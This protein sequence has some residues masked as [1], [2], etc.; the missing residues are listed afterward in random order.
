MR[1][2]TVTD[3][4]VRR[5][6]WQYVADG[7]AGMARKGLRAVYAGLLW[8]PVTDDTLARRRLVPRLVVRMSV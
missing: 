4:L 7:A 8:L 5:Q 1:G 2:A 3:D 6:A